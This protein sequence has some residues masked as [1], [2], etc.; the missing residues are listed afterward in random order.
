MLRN[1]TVSVTPSDGRFTDSS[2]YW[3]VPLA[4]GSR[5]AVDAPLTILNIGGSF[6]Y[7]AAASVVIVPAEQ[8]Q[9]LAEQPQKQEN[10]G[11][12]QPA[13][14]EETSRGAEMKE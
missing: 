4:W 5:V 11:Q 2:V 13:R 10:P 8:I 12:A 3:R 9:S 14:Q 1:Q 7:R 6:V